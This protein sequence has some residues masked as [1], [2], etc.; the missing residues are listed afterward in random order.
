MCYFF[1]MGPAAAGVGL[2]CPNGGAFAAIGANVDVF[3]ALQDLPAKFHIFFVVPDLL[4]GFAFEVAQRMLCILVEAAGY[5]QSV[6]GDNG[7]VPEAPAMIFQG[8]FWYEFS[9]VVLFITA[10][11]CL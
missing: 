1:W 4:E 11:F 7:G 10:V 2:I 8:I 6:P 5:D 9:G 3:T